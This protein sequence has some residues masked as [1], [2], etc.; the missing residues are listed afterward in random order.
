V[1]IKA[2]RNWRTLHRRNSVRALILGAVVQAAGGAWS[3]V[4]NFYFYQMPRWLPF[5]VS[6]AIFVLGL[7]AAYTHQSS[8]E[9]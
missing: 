8:V 6:G 7:V 5:A 4:P 9:D 1:R 2:T 3:T